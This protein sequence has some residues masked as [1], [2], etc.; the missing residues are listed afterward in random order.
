MATWSIKNLERMEADGVVTVVHW[1][2]EATEGDNTVTA[3]GT[4]YF[5]TE[6]SAEGFIAYD[7]LTEETVLGWIEN[8]ETIEAGLAEKL[9][10]MAEP[11]PITGMPWA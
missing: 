9:T 4:S 5:E 2:C 7:N 10:A 1:A 11:Q 8:K 3:T 6:S